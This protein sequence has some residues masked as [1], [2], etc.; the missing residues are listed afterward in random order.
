MGRGSFGN[1]IIR[2]V[3][4]VGLFA[5]AWLAVGPAISFGIFGQSTEG[6]VTGYWMREP[7]IPIGE[8]GPIQEP[9]V[10]VPD[11]S[12]SGCQTVYRDYRRERPLPGRGA[13][14]EVMYWPDALANC[15]AKSTV[16]A[17]WRLGLGAVLTLSGLMVAG[18]AVED[19]AV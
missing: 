14:I 11:R 17:W 3:V 8:G 13:T 5:L 1:A 9:K 16:H 12:P 15:Y 18:S 6:R 10:H 19:L 7:A 2:I 4:A